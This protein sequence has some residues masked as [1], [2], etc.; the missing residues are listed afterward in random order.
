MTIE[1]VLEDICDVCRPKSLSR[2][3]YFS[4]DGVE[5]LKED[6]LKLINDYFLQPKRLTIFN[7]AE[8]E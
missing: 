8:E 3:A 7:F 5:P 1:N 6:I 2:Q 4:N